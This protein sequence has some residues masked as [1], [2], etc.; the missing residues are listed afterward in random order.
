MKPRYMGILVVSA[1]IAVAGLTSNQN[2]AQAA[3]HGDPDGLAAPVDGQADIADFYAWHRDGTTVFAISL[4][5]AQP[6]T[7]AADLAYD[8]DVLHGIHID[9]D[10]DSVPDENIWVRF[11]QDADDAW[12]VQVAGVPG[13]DAAIE[14]AVETTLS[15]GS[16]QVFVGLRDDPFFFDVAGFTN[17]VSTG[18]LAFSGLTDTGPVDGI[19]GANAT[20]IVIEVPTADIGATAFQTWATSGRIGT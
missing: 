6:A 11:G 13:T 16:V 1:L 3:D 14:G 9:T 7:A 17:T 19:A 20:L 4:L 18:N 2:P 12:G 15:S 8:R 10:G 5:G